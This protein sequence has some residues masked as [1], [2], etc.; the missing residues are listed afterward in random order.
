[1]ESYR[2]VSETEWTWQQGSRHYG[3]RVFPKRGTLIWSGWVETA[4]SPL[5]DEGVS[6]TFERFSQQGAPSGFEPPSELLVELR[7][8]VTSTSRRGSWLGWTGKK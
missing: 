8:V 2:R 4:E 1:M 5:F 7:Q 6:Q 3:V